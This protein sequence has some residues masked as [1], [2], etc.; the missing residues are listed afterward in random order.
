M[1]SRYDLVFSVPVEN[2]DFKLIFITGID[3]IEKIRFRVDVNSLENKAKDGIPG[4]CMF[5]MDVPV[6]L[7]ISEQSDTIPSE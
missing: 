7:I 3:G 2:R 5:F 1:F 6:T 4:G